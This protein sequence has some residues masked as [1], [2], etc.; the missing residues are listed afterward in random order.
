[1]RNSEIIV[2]IK[3]NFERLN[4]R[5]NS[6]VKPLINSIIGQIGLLK[7]VDKDVNLHLLKIL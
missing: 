7:A 6:V 4:A 1:M 2:D 3:A 5:K